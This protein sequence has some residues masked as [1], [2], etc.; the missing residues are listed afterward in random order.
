M[1]KL[2]LVT[3]LLSGCNMTPVDIYSEPMEFDWMPNELQ[4]QHNIINCRAQLHCGAA[5]LFRR[6]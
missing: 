5:D 3:I 6:V 1:K 4:W 2:L